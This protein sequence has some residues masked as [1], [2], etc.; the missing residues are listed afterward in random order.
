[1]MIDLLR[2]RRSIRKFTEQAIDA[3]TLEILKEAILRTPSSKNSMAC[4]FIFV[5]DR[6]IIDQLSRCKPT[7]AG[8]LNSAQLAVVIMVNEGETAAWIEDCSIASIIVQLTAHSLQLGSC[9]VQIRGRDYSDEK[10][11]E[12]YVRETLNIPVGYRVLS[13]VAIGYPQRSHEG[14]PFEELNFGKIHR[15]KF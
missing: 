9:W 7:G 8:P 2:T 1:M 12:T 3:E 4:E 5:D 11:S 13:I 6:S 15:Y 10:N 14:R